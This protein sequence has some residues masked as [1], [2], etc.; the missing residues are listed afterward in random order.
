[1]SCKKTGRVLTLRLNRTD[2]KNA[3]TPDMYTAMAGI[4]RQV[5]NDP[6][7]RVV[8]VTGT[9]DCFSAG[10]DLQNFVD[11]PPLTPDAPAFQFMDA[12]MNLSKPVIAAVNGVAA[13]ICTTLLFHCDPAYAVPEAR[14]LMP[15]VNLA[16][17]PE[18]GS[19]VLLPRLVGY[20]KP[21]S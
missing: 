19:T 6:G 18:Y 15:F 21:P 10:N 13:D 9:G 12:F 16:L 17:V 7:V 1:M 2:K 8:V 14:F 4:L 20:V 3:A 5:D 11:D